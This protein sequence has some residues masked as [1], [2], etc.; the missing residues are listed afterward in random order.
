MIFYGLPEP[1][2][3]SKN[4]PGARAV[5]FPKYEPIPSHGDPIRPKYYHFYKFHNFSQ[6]PKISSTTHFPLC[7]DLGNFSHLKFGDPSKLLRNALVYRHFINRK[8]TYSYCRRV[9]G[10]VNRPICPKA[11]FEGRTFFECFLETR[12]F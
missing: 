5:I 7:P 8:F 1:P 4:L 10:I 9:S 6:P 2:E 12:Y 3:P 11:L